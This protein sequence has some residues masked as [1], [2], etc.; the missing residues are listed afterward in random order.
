MSII[1][2]S[3]ALRDDMPVWPGS[4]DF[5]IRRQM[6]MG[7]GD[8]CNLSNMRI[9]LHMGTHVDAPLHFIRDGKAVDELSLEIFNGP[10]FV[11]DLG[12]AREISSRELEASGLPRGM[13]RVL[14]KTTNSER[15]WRKR[16][17]DAS[18]VAL[19]P[20]GARW[21][22]DRRL[23][24]VGSD[25]LSVQRFNDTPEVHHILLGAGVGVLEGVDLS[26]VAA[27]GY[28][29]IC[30][31]IKVAGAEGAP[32]RAALRTVKENG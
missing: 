17:F 7:N 23:R 2:I 31:P 19:T 1:D 21:L 5:E 15:L 13:E 26:G 16:E 25:Y 11:A 20:D 24:M 9:D 32:A 29:L 14:F 18:F 28:E 27:G 4:V 8:A 12:A 6:S 10:V 3:V 22:V 30:L